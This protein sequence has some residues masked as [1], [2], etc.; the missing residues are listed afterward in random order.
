VTTRR[1]EFTV[2]GDAEPKGSARAFVPLA[3]ARAA[4]YQG[5]APRAVVTSDNPASKRWQDRIARRARA[6]VG[7]APFVG[8]VSV[9][10]T[11][12]L[13]RPPS[14]R[15]RWHTTR[16]DVDKLTRCVLDALTGTAV[17]D[18]GQV[19]EVHARKRYAHTTAATWVVVTAAAERDAV[20]PNW[21][22]TFA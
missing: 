7:D 21:I 5:R 11:F 13:T 16:P 20:Q 19:V 9:A 6:V 10:I 8:P 3:W 17:I 22:D 2:R 4:V 14:V 1:V 12:A 18:D 15:R